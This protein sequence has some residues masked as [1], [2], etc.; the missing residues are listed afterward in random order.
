ML[1]ARLQH[2][3]IALQRYIRLGNGL[4]CHGGAVVVKVLVEEHGVVSLLLGL[5]LVPVGKAIQPLGLKVVG[6]IQ[7][8]VGGVEL[9]VDLLVQQVSDRFIQHSFLLKK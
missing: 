1:Q 9:L 4:Q 2:A 3:H 7:I 8:Q 5:D 6:E